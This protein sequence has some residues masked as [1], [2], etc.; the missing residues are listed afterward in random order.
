MCFSFGLATLVRGHEAVETVGSPWW[1]AP[2]VGKAVYGLPSDMFSFGVCLG[3]IVTRDAAED[4]RLSMTYQRRGTLDFGVRPENYVKEYA[5]QAADTPMPLIE[6][7]MRCCRENPAER[8]T[9]FQVVSELQRLQD[10][11]T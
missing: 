2:E 8:P 6:L 11:F 5:S 9:A 1:R 7:T 10:D 3:E 4:I